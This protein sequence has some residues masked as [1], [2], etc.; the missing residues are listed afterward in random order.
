MIVVLTDE[1]PQ[2]ILSRVQVAVE[3][4]GIDVWNLRP[5]DEPKPVGQ[6]VNVLVML[7]MGQ[8]D[9]GCADLRDEAEIAVVITPRRSPTVIEQVLMAVDAMEVEI[10]SVQEKALFCI[11]S[12]RSETEWLNDHVARLAAGRD[13]RVCRVD[14]RIVAA[15]PQMR[16]GDVG[17]DTE[18][19]GRLGFGVDDG[20]ENRQDTLIGADDGCLHFDVSGG[21]IAIVHIATKRSID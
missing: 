4:H 20:I 11:D 7:I 16:I 18:R 17:L 2:L 13:N 19:N 10:I 6:I 5:N 15:L 8:S 21:C 14:V 9:G 12:E 1:L 3:V